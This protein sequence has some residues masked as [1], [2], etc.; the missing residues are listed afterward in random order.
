MKLP[1][2]L[3]IGAQ[4]SATSA[5]YRQLDVHE[6]VFLS[7]RKE[8]RFFS[9]DSLFERGAEYYATFFEDAGDVRVIGEATP[10]YLAVPAAAARIHG[11]IPDAKLFCCL[12]NPIDRAYSAFLMQV[13][14]G[15]E[16]M[17]R[18]FEDAIADNTIYL[19][20]GR[21]ATQLERYLDYFPRKQLMVVLL[22]DLKRDAAGVYRELCGFL[23]IR[24]FT[25][26][27]LITEDTNV[28]G[29]PKSASVQRSTNTLFRIRNRIRNTPLR[30]L[31]D[32]PLVDNLS[33]DVRNRVSQWNRAE[34]SF[35][36]LSPDTRRELIPVFQEENNR[37]AALL[38]RDLSHWNAMP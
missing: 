3:I 35:P 20:Y 32:N 31:V 9:E 27:E 24:P 23:G 18:R 26:D 6:D 25:D 19:D 38:D 30:F 5:I 15:S 12:R 29:V 7:E 21:Y 13:S 14:K 4:K 28:G 16:P 36:K 11:M 22:E 8:L 17:D 10:H 2:F 37:L 33:R 1:N 34:G